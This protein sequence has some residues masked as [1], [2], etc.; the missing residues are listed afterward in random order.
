M[1]LAETIIIIY[2]PYKEAIVIFNS[3]KISPNFLIAT[4]VVIL[5]KRDLNQS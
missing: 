5:K 2:L 1:L 3:W 4:K